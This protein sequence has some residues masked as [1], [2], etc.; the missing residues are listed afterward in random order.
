MAA[1]GAMIFNAPWWLWGYE[2][3]YWLYSGYGAGVYCGENSSPKFIECTITGNRTRGG[4]SGIGGDN[5]GARSEPVYSYQIPT[6][7]GGVYCAKGSSVEFVDCNIANNVS[8]KAEANDVNNPD[9]TTPYHLDPYLGHGGGVAF[10]E[11]ASVKFTNCVISGNEAS[12]GGGMFWANGA[13]QII[14][15]NFVGNRAYQGAGMFGGHGKAEISN[16]IVHGNTARSEP[17]DPDIVPGQG[18]G[19]FSNAMELKIADS[20]LYNNVASASGG[21]IYLNGSDSNSPQ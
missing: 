15:C 10:E 7:G 13:V 3:D 19:I 2:G 21:G 14:D 17:N 18:G 16:T 1:T 5:V 6:Y 8:P 12:V 20:N 11:T 4:M 9:T